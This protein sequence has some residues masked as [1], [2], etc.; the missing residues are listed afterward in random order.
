[1]PDGSQMALELRCALDPVAFAIERLGFTPDPWQADVLRLGNDNTLLNCSR[2]SGKSTTTAIL[3]LH[4]A[5]Y[6]RKALVLLGSPSQRQS[7]ELFAKVAGFL[8]LLEPVPMLEEDNR[9]SFT[10][11]NGSRVVS[12]PGSSET[13]RGFSAPTLIVEDEAAYVADS[14]YWAIRPM[15]AVSDGRMVLMSSPNGK[16][17]HFYDEWSDG[18][19]DWHRVEVPATECPRITEAFLASERRALGETW[20]RQEYLCEFADVVDAVFRTEDIERAVTDEVKPLFTTP[21]ID[22]DTVTPLRIS[23]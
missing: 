6:Q 23:A 8:K 4:T 16:R 22:D 17:G 15:L 11:A 7:R 13:V 19:E 21:P 14:F 1:M 20:F 12:L 18:G 3:A 10:L 2:Q 5:V 9:L